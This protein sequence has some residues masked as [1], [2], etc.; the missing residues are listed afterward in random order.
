MDGG[1]DVHSAFGLT[2]ETVADQIV[3]MYGRTPTSEKSASYIAAINI[4]KRNY[5]KQYLE[6]WNSTTELTGTGRAVDAFIMP[7]AAIA[8]ARPK[9]YNYY[10]GNSFCHRFLIPDP[11]SV[12]T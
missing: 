1:H 3:T 8:A 4:E 10:G 6:Y 11:L 9:L 12:L 5:Q 2:G 7:V